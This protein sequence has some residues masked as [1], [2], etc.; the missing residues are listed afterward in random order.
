MRDLIA[1]TS[2]MAIPRMKARLAGQCEG[3]PSIY[4]QLVCPTQRFLCTGR[5]N[6]RR[7]VSVPSRYAVTKHGQVQTLA[8]E[9]VIRAST[10][11]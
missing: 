4:V 9:V 3:E 8:R 11:P 5:Q 1:H 6:E 7:H 10:R 2:R